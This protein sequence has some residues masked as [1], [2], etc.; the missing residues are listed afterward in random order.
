MGG[1]GVHCGSTLLLYP[2]TCIADPSTTA[3]G[4]ALA[5]LASS[6]VKR[7]HADHYAPTA[8]G[9]SG[10]IAAAAP[11]AASRPVVPPLPPLRMQYTATGTPMDALTSNRD[12][13]RVYTPVT[14][15][16]SRLEAFMTAASPAW[17]YSGVGAA[18]AAVTATAR[19]RHASPSRSGPVTA[20]M[21][22]LLSVAADPSTGSTDA[23][24][25][26]AAIPPAS[27]S[28]G[29]RG[30]VAASTAVMHTPLLHLHPGAV[31][32]AM[33][34]WVAGVP[35]AAAMWH[36]HQRHTQQQTAEYLMW[37]H[38]QQAAAAAA[39]AASTMGITSPSFLPPPATG[40]AAFEGG[41]GWWLHHGVA[42]P[43]IRL[44]VLPADAAAGQWPPR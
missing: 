42:L 3:A 40:V 43:P 30:K 26:V 20:A 22:A 1:C 14:T 29:G 25:P 35:D 36:L 17:S 11:V 12:T 24:L 4:A 37:S 31:L 6:G 39:V 21:E 2:A 33:P 19:S 23:I 41:A 7:R 38:H 8:G 27:G 44:P 9:G 32:P 28:S 13:L 16:T 10:S 18:A 5:A 34:T 15:A